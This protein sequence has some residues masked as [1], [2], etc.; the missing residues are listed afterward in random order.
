[1]PVNN[2]IQIRKG[3]FSEWS[4]TD[5]VLGNGEPGFDTSHGVLK[6]GDG[7]N[8]WSSLTPLTSNVP[9][10]VKNTTGSPMTKGQAVYINGAQGDHPTIQ[11]AIANGESSSSK[12]LG[13]LQ[14]NLSDNE[15]GYVTVEGL[16]EGINTNSATVAGDTIWL[17]PTVSGG[18]VYGTSNKPSAP[19]HMVFIGYVLRKQSNNGKVYIKVQNG[20]ELEEL[21]NVAISGVSN[22]QA[23]IYNSASGLW[24]NKT[25]DSSYINNF[26]E[27]VQDVVG[28]GF[29]VAG[30]GIT[31]DY[32]DISNTLTISSSGT[33]GGGGVSIANAG[34][35]RILTSDGT[36]TG[37]SAETNLTFDGTSLKVNNIDVSVSGHSHTSS[38]ISD[39]NSSVSGLLP[40]TNISA[41]SGISVSSSSG[42]YTVNSTTILSYATTASFPVTGSTDSYYLASDTS[43]L[44]QWTGSLYV[45]MGPPMTGFT[46]AQAAINLYLWSNFR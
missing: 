31:L 30:S 35:N 45:E 34:D 11:L 1:M 29:L 41:G 36:S 14:Q 24:L 17:S 10:Y 46:N 5:P 9:L 8:N 38:D 19:N 3:S 25:L 33:G 20:F 39:F 15:F 6:I 26:G 18:V 23:L 7:V 27:S 28:S 21:H 16:L 22:N 43:R 13:L 44:Y 42:N 12:T 4:S 32:N 40:V 37:I 2:L